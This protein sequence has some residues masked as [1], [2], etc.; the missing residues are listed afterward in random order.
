MAYR[1]AL[2]HSSLGISA[3]ALLLCGG[4]AARLTQ[5][6]STTDLA[7][8]A[9][10]LALTA[11]SL[12]LLTRTYPFVAL[13]HV[14]V[15]CGLGVWMCLFQIAQGGML[16]EASAYGTV[17]SGYA[18]LLLGIEE[19]TRGCATRRKTAD[20]YFISP[21]SPS[22]DLFAA[23]LPG[24][25]VGVVLASV[26][27]AIIGL[28][29]GP[30]VIFTFAAGSLAMLWST[31]L[32]PSAQPV[33]FSIVLGYLAL[34]SFT[35]WRLFSWAN[36]GLTVCWLSLATSLFALA[37]WAAGMFAAS[38]PA[39]DL[40]VR[41]SLR[42][43]TILTWLVFPLSIF[44]AISSPA[45]YRIAVA[46]FGVNTL[47]LVV[48][49]LAQ[50]RPFLAYRAITSAVIG[51]Y[52]VVFCVGTPSPDTTFALGLVAVLLSLVFSA[53]GFACRWR[54]TSGYELDR[55]FAVPL[56]ASALL[57]TTVAVIPAY[58]SPWTMLL[59]GLSFLL[60]VKGIPS[61]H[62]LY[63]TVA[64]LGCAVY[65]AVLADWPR[66]RLV[67][68]AMV[69]AY[70]LWIVGLL[71][72]RTESA[73]VKLLKLSD[74]R[75]DVPLFNSAVAAS[76]V[77][78]ILRVNETLDGSIPWSTSAP[79]AL[80]LAVFCLLM[81][82]AYPHAAWVHLAV[83]L[84]STSVGLAAYPKLQPGIW[85]FPLGMAMAILWDMVA[86]LAR[87]FE[88]PIRAWSGLGDENHTRP[89]ELWS[90]AFFAVTSALSVLIVTAVVVATILGLI[91]P[92]DPS[93]TASW[94]A[95]ELAL[96]LGVA[97][98]AAVAWNRARAEAVMAI[99]GFVLLAIWWLAAPISPLIARMSVDA[100]V[101]LPLSTAVV[102]VCVVAAG[103]GL[104]RR[105]SWQ[106]PFWKR[107][108]DADPIARLDAFARQAGLG[109]SLIA[110][111]MTRFESNLTTVGTLLMAT[112]APGLSAIL[113]RSVA[114]SYAAGLTWC[115]AAFFVGLDVVR[116]LAV[117]VD[118]DK[119][120]YVSASLLAAVAILWVVA[121]IL[122][123]GGE[124]TEPA[125]SLVVPAGS[126]GLAFEQVA[127]LASLLAGLRGDLGLPRQSI[128]YSLGASRGWCALR[129]VCV[130]D[131]S[132]RPVEF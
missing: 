34:V 16:A 5:H 33:H 115:A 69:G 77:A 120:V 11:T 56:F 128:E 70:Q 46:A 82:K 53:I 94:W 50:R 66:D 75:Y 97:H 61:R 101:F 14:T 73:L 121:G 62:W 12:G 19:A 43:S 118:A 81:V 71:V 74:R 40:Y 48:L 108:V 126:V 60:M 10:T 68:A 45:L 84:A 25:E 3:I 26:A 35:A 102:A 36:V 99:T 23:A 72:R 111:L 107:D 83:T 15:A 18:L 98:V 59:V 9:A 130:R 78:V 29:N 17:A 52:V 31:R 64:A 32:R 113:R 76:V 39:L 103:L 127:F 47:T 104:A 51:V 22:V 67:T 28:Q 87:R 2:D 41:P 117:T 96:A 100:R 95:L 27:L 55:L 8:L 44:G 85:W 93:G 89:V 124:A 38:R 110:A 80:N 24:F 123:R 30:A 49:T 106:G 37:L 90:Q 132:D 54:A 91:D 129:P 57:L 58:N 116:R 131:R 112:A 105:P 42:A 122:R 79:L 92:P 7:L 21:I 125:E 1:R 4:H 119:A 6:L 65:F 20:A 88:A 86:R 114:S 13:A 109:L 63:A